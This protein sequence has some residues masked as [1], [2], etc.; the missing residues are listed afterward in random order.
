MAV[1]WLGAAAVVADDDGWQHFYRVDPEDRPFSADA[2]LW[3]KLR[4]PVGIRAVFRTSA[5]LLELAV[6]AGQDCSPVD[7]VVDGTLAH[8]LPVSP[9]ESTLRAPL[10]GRPVQVEVWLP[11]YGAF[12]I[13]EPVLIGGD[14]TPAVETGLTWITYGSSISQ[15]RGAAG[16]SETWP[17]L[18]ARRRGWQLT[19][20]GIAGQCHLDP[21]IARTIRHTPADLISLCLGINI[22]TDVTFNR[23]SLQPHV[24]GFVQTIRDQQTEPPIAV[25]TAIRCPRFEGVRN[26][27]GMTPDDVRHEVA[28]AV[29]ALTAVGDKNLH[30]VDGLTL[31]GPE[32]AERFLPDGLHPSADG[33]RVLAERMATALSGVR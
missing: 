1:R 22:Y 27:A 5:G 6:L 21:V 13:Q 2:D 16:P 17:A 32:E 25:V 28:E 9:G 19:C 15:C 7:V 10:P 14:A 30:L 23:R 20:L 3:A 12:S 4:M 31:F 24:A 26:A 8:R 29:A 11:Q 33:Y 18:V